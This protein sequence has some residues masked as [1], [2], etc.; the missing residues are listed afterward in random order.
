MES[1]L[2]HLEFS[3]S[4]FASTYCFRE[5]ENV[6]KNDQRHSGIRR[7]RVDDRNLVNLSTRLH[8]RPFVPS[9][10]AS[11]TEIFD[12]WPRFARDKN[13][14][15]NTVA[16][17]AFSKM[18]PVNRSPCLYCTWRGLWRISHARAFRRRLAVCK[19]QTYNHSFHDDHDESGPVRCKRSAQEGATDVGPRV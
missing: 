17:R 7:R 5:C 3:F 19:C 18:F 11:R 4:P 8:P 14:H 13:L 16:E 9:Y 2:F 15:V 6:L 1:E 10:T 12:R